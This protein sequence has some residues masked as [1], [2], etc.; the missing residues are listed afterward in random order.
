[1]TAKEKIG[2]VVKNKMNKTVVIIVET[3]Y[4][5]PLYKKTLKKTNRFMAHDELNESLVGDKVLIMKTRP[6]SN[7]KN[8]I[9]KQTLNKI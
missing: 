2:T 8:W 5:H 6:L 7:K 3:L 9:V 1:M 4:S